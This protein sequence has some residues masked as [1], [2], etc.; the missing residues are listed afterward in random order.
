MF[1]FFSNRDPWIQE[2]L[3]EKKQKD[4]E[5]EAF[6]YSRA[7]APLGQTRALFMAPVDVNEVVYGVGG[8]LVPEHSYVS[9]QVQDKKSGLW[10]SATRAIPG[11]NFRIQIVKPVA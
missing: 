11:Q 7:R 1:N 6:D 3:Q 8:A 5:Q 4:L 2:A 10:R 9:F